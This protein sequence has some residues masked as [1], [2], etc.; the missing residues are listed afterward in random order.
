MASK[1]L[2]PTIYAIPERNKEPILNVLKQIFQQRFD[3]KL[4]SSDDDDNGD[5]GKS[6]SMLLKFL[7]IGLYPKKIFFLN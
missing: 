2:R 6:S 3:Y 7:E 5:D 1:I 4:S